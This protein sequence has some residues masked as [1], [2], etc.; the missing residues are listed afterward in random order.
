[1][2]GIVGRPTPDVVKKALEVVRN[3]ILNAVAEEE[4]EP[5]RQEC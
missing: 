5:E 4:L 3:D 2:F 1:M